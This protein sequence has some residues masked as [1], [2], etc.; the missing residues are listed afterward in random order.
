M[1][2]RNNKPVILIADDEPNILKFLSY[3]V[4]ALGYDTVEVPD[5]AACINKIKSNEISGLLLDINMPKRTGMEVLAFVRENRPS[6]PV[7]MVTA[8]YE[9]DTAV[10]A[11]KMGAFEYLTKPVDLD[12]LATTLRNAL[13][14]KSLSDEVGKLRKQL[15]DSEL[16]TGIIGECQALQ[17]MFE[18]T[19]K[20]I[21]T[22]VNVLI[23]GESGTGKELLARA[24]HKGSKR[25]SGPFVA[26]NCSAITRELADSLLFGH[27]RGSFTGATEDR[28]GFFEQA[29]KG[30]IFLD[31][32]GDMPLAIQAKV[33]R[34]LED[35]FVRRVGEKNE[36]AVDF[37]VIAATNRDFARSIAAEEFRKDLYFRLEEYPIFLPPLRDRQE[38][39][40]I[41]ARHFLSDFC[42]VNDLQPKQ[43]SPAVLSALN[44]H[45]WPGNIRE[46]KNVIR[47]AAIQAPGSTIN[48]V[49]FSNVELT[50][51]DTSKSTGV[52]RNQPTVCKGITPLEDIEREAILNA[53]RA[54][55]NSAEAAKLLGI[56]KATLY[57]KLKTFN[58]DK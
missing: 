31:E 28:A 30:T 16:F 51:G 46:L 42:T 49:V 52:S 40:P 38:D 33:L 24:V 3:N 5:G 54:T 14:V 4:Q 29:E 58:I 21:E 57:R 9:I 7:I 55:E 26:V 2:E 41:I 25:S 47:R 19:R 36:R 8:A 10:T 22:E 13:S 56:S 11:I 27:K 34:V 17:D 35:G 20:V 39:I 44:K 50:A 37:R 53:H 15:S 45:S 23:I 48:Q 12:R 32:I 43:L 1:P 18:A 6:I